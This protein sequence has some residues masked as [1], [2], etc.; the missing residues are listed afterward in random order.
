MLTLG[1]FTER[2]LRSLLENLTGAPPEIS[3]IS[4]N[5]SKKYAYVTFRTWQDKQKITQV[6]HKRPISMLI[7]DNGPTESFDVSRIHA[8]Y[9]KFVLGVS[10]FTSNNAVFRE[11]GQTSVHISGVVNAVTYYHRL[12]SNITIE[13]DKVLCAAFSTMKSFS[14]PWLDR[15]HYIFARNGLEDVFL[16][17]STY[18][19]VLSNMSLKPDYKMPLDKRSLQTLGVRHILNVCICSPKVLNINHRGTYIKLGPR[20]LEPCSQKLEQMARH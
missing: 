8:K 20:R 7:E 2:T 13:K 9:L 18:K 10:K 5:R 16:D 12:L 1:K 15:L 3:T 14:H 4:L 11:L 6:V 17:L 19:K